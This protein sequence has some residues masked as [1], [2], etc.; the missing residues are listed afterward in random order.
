MQQKAFEIDPSFSPFNKTDSKGIC[1]FE[2]GFEM[3]KSNFGFQNSYV[4]LK[5]KIL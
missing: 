3:R 4:F 5:D 1:R 2:M